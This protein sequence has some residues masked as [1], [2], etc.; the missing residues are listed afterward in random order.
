MR[1]FFVQNVFFLLL[2]NLVVKPVWIFGIDRNVQNYVGHTVYGQYQAILSFCIIFQIFLD[3]GLQSF[4]N[5]TVAQA[6]ETM[7][8]LF[9]N[10]AW[11]KVLL[12]V[13]Y[14]VLIFCFGL[15]IGFQSHALFLLLILGF[16]QIV[17]SFLLFL[18]SNVSGMHRFRTDSILSVSD[19]LLMIIICGALLYLPP[20]KEHF[21]IEWFI[22][23]QIASYLIS[24]LLAFIICLRLSSLK[25]HRFHPAKVWAIARK[26]LP[27]AILIFSMSVYLRADSVIL[28]RILP[29]GKEEAGIFAASFRLL[30]VANNMSGVLFAGILLPMFGRLLAKRE[31]VRPLVHQSLNLLLPVAFTTLVLA[32]FFGNDIMHLLYTEATN[33]DGKV[34]FL[35]M[36]SFPGFCIGYVYA[37]LLTANGNLRPLISI[38]LIAVAFNLLLNFLLIPT[39]GAVGAAVSCAATQCLLSVL[40]IRLAGRLISLNW[41]WKWIFQYLLFGVFIL[42]AGWLISQLDVHLLLK[43]LGMGMAGLSGMAFCGFLPFRKAIEAFRGKGSFKQ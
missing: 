39:Y 32:G 7:Q 35:L 36:C 34:F 28:E 10:I 18:R 19:K 23:A 3:F 20:W 25:W 6:P 40:N 41:D 11:A 13:I 43:I 33:Y 5:R 8:T 42:V 4:N 37:T 38:S 15:L 22:Y 31:S 12:S 30:D 1:K 2:V 16:V 26:S 29:N 14:Y 24:S 21:K 27:Y 9:P 17:N